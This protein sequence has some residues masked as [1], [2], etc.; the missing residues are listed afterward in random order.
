M[1]GKHETDTLFNYAT[2]PRDGG[3]ALHASI[4][5]TSAVD[6][7]HSSL[8]EVDAATLRGQR[9]V[10]A[11]ATFQTGSNPHTQAQGYGLRGSF[12]HTGLAHGMA[13]AW[14]G[15][16]TGFVGAQAPP[17]RVV[18][19]APHAE[20]KPPPTPAPGTSG[21]DPDPSAEGGPSRRARP[22]SAP[23]PPPSPTGLPPLVVGGRVLSEDLGTL[24]GA[25]V[26]GVAGVPASLWQVTAVDDNTVL[27]SQVTL[28]VQRLG[29][30]AVAGRPLAPALEG[31]TLQLGFTTG[32]R[33]TYLLNLEADVPFHSP[34]NGSITAR[35][36]H[37][38]TSRRKVLNP[39]EEAHVK[40]IWNYVDF[41]V[42]VTRKFAAPYSTEITAGASWQANRAM[43]VKGAAGTH[44]GMDATVAWRSWG[45]PVFTASLTGAL[46]PVGG[47]EA[48]SAMTSFRPWLG[49]RLSIEKGGRARY[50][51]PVRGYQSGQAYR[52]F[53]AL[54]YLN[55][56]IES[57]PVRGEESLFLDPLGGGAGQR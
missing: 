19:L 9:G 5:P 51:Q 37:S 39:A 1:F 25:S 47:E 52:H 2:A 7:P 54:P 27:G 30:A 55:E 35:Y 57:G 6:L 13:Q 22:G 11:G 45:D 50:A 34:G 42:E 53:T 8:V 15:P 33:P 26:W 24:F 48:P 46:R 31:S 38:M 40:G 29:Q 20:W 41:G 43:L 18:R 14:S 10:A 28:P 32:E 23:P 36:L 49:L 12:E 3:A 4:R 17:D 16:A 21:S 56:R 44:R